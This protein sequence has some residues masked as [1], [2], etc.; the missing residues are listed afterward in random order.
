MNNIVAIF[1]CCHSAGLARCSGDPLLEMT[2][3]GVTLLNPPPFP[4]DQDK[5]ILDRSNA[6]NFLDSHRNRVSAYIYIAAASRQEY[7]WEI[8]SAGV[9]ITCLLHVLK[10][11]RE[12][13][14]QL[15]Y[16]SLMDKV[17]A[18]TVKKGLD[19]ALIARV[20]IYTVAYFLLT[21]KT[22]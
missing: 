20:S 11:E 10:T 5:N 18:L 8:Y 2:A 17:S 21:S 4:I 7:A 3:R 19:K 9:F 14:E 15:T 13:F 22:A 1:D 6:I 16:K 12:G